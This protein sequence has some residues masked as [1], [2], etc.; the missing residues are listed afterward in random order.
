MSC[1]K[2]RPVGRGAVTL[3]KLSLAH[4]GVVWMSDRGA[5]STALHVVDEGG[6]TMIYECGVNA[7][8]SSL[9][10]WRD[11]GIGGQKLWEISGY[12]DAQDVKVDSI[13]GNVWLWQILDRITVFDSN[14]VEINN[15]A[16]AGT[17]GTL[18]HDALVDSGNGNM[19]LW[20]PTSPGSGGVWQFDT[21]L[22]EVA[23]LESPSGVLPRGD[24]LTGGVSGWVYFDSDG[25]NNTLISFRDNDLAQEVATVNIANVTINDSWKA[26]A[27][28]LV[29]EFNG[30]SSPHVNDGNVYSY[31]CTNATQKW[32]RTD[33][34]I[35]FN[36]GN[37]ANEMAFIDTVDNLYHNNLKYNSDGDL[38]W[39]AESG[40][41]S[42]RV[43]YDA[44]SGSLVY[45]G[46]GTSVTRNDPSD[47]TIIWRRSADSISVSALKGAQIFGD[48]VYLCGAR[49]TIP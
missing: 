13:N 48:A 30:A 2:G 17:G 46:G 31:D 26:S 10:K 25:S 6:E 16:N 7:S 8:G 47:G 38:L 35:Q 4:G 34:G 40:T 45:H 19:N 1:C 11:D 14:G 21:S 24:R 28:T 20:R 49:R 43:M 9:S 33:L 22:T 5:N 12:S 44:A 23:S 29:F 15:L 27:S 3:V 37:T 42:G 41:S 39:T 32:V 18:D 36:S